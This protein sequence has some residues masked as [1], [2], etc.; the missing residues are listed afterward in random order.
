MNKPILRLDDKTLVI[1]DL[2]LGIEEEYYKKGFQILNQE[3]QIH[4]SIKEE[5]DKKKFEQLIIFGDAKHNI[6]IAGF[7]E[8]K[9][10]YTLFEK[11][12]TLT[13]VKIIP[14]NHDGGLERLLPSR[15]DILPVTGY[16]LYGKYGLFHGHAWPD[17]RL[18]EG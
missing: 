6:P 1:A 10:L 5:F 17:K 8:S 2:H 14:G 13:K 16:L 12:L 9:K 3:K 7:Y 18:F 15:V 11:L 4:D